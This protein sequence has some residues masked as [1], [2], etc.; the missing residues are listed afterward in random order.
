MTDMPQKSSTK[1]GILFV[2]LHLSLLFSSLGGV[3]SKMAA[4]SPMFSMRFFFYYGLVLF[5]MFVYAVVWQQILKYIP[6]T[7]AFSNK[8]VS[9]VW[10]MVWGA[11]FFKEEIRWNM[12]LGSLIIFAGIYMVVTSDE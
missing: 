8:P 4:G 9:L 5:I 10:G 11:L 12:I 6:L 2:V 1:K 3:A 7:M